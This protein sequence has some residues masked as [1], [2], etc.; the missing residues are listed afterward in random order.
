MLMRAALAALLLT[1]P[2]VTSWVLVRRLGH[3]GAD[4]A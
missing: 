4:N 3:P 2:F 1:I